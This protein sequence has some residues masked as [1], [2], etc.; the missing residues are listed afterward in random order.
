MSARFA[1]GLEDS[2][3]TMSHG[4]FVGWVAFS[5]ILR[6]RLRARTIKSLRNL[7]FAELKLCSWYEINVSPQRMLNDSQNMQHTRQPADSDA[8]AVVQHL[9]KRLVK[10]KVCSRTSGKHLRRALVIIENNHGDCA[11]LNVLKLQQFGK[12]LA[13][14]MNFW[15]QLCNPR[16]SSHITVFC[17]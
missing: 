2:V 11:R 12:M 13:V 6:S 17:F 3:E 4:M 9:T 1:G 14:P 5:C 10:R 8:E 15:T 16:C 7:R